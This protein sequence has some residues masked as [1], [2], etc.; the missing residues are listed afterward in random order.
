MSTV[1]IN[2]RTVGNGHRPY[3]IA[4]VGINHNGDPVLAREMVAAAWEAGADA[5]KIQTFITEKFLHPSHPGYQPRSRS[6]VTPPSMGSTFF[7]PRKNSTA[8]TSSRPTIRR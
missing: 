7:P 6:G 4:E 1:T 2:G 8:S 5:V 3:I